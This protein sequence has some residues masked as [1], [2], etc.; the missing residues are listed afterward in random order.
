M[1]GPQTRVLKLSVLDE[2]E[3]K[4]ELIGDTIIQLQPAYDSNPVDGYDEWHPLTYKGKYAGEVYLELTFYSSRPALPAKQ[5]VHKNSSRQIVSA[6]SGS[7]M[8]S[9]TFTSS[10]SLSM[11]TAS[12]PL[13]EQPCVNNGTRPLRQNLVT[14]PLGGMSTP[15]L[16]QVPSRS[17]PGTVRHVGL[18]AAIRYV[19]PTGIVYDMNSSTNTLPY[20]GGIG[21]G[22]QSQPA[23]IEIS[24]LHGMR[25]GTPGYPMDSREPSPSGFM[26][27][28]TVS[29]S[30][31]NPADYQMEREFVNLPAIPPE[32][33]SVHREDPTWI[34]EEDPM[35]FFSIPLP[36]MEQQKP[37]EY[38]KEE[39]ED[40]S[41]RENPYE[42]KSATHLY[43]PTK[44]SPLT[45]STSS[46]ETVEDPFQPVTPKTDS[47]RGSSNSSGSNSES[48]DSPDQPHYPA[49]QPPVQK[50][51]SA[52]GI[53]T[54]PTT[55]EG[56]KPTAVRRKPITR[57]S[58][59]PP[60]MQDG[61]N[62]SQPG[63]DDSDTGEIDVFSPDSYISAKQQEQ[64]K[65]QQLQQEQE[66]KLK[67]TLH[68]STYAPQ[69]VFVTPA[70]PLP[71]APGDLVDPGVGRYLGEGQWDLTNEL[72]AGYCEDVY[73]GV[74][75]NQFSRQY[76]N[77][78]PKN[79]LRYNK[80]RLSLP[81]PPSRV[82]I[83]GGF[84]STNQ[85]AH[86]LATRK[87]SVRR[88]PRV[89]PKIPVG[90]TCEEFIATEYSYYSDE[91]D[92]IRYIN[93]ID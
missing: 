52:G 54:A 69:P 63:K 21:A 10:V 32:N 47:Y 8:G 4:P 1:E 7:V 26:N 85:H 29:R 68:E 37:Q 33:P 5:P 6:P 11:S 45:L 79:N 12:R 66:A 92:G 71:Q 23:L 13:P 27:M 65:L 46:N 50:R 2:T 42:N 51:T 53:S 77:A 30:L 58:V 22:Q 73:D 82:D 83:N 93:A 87:E 72:N 19:P 35:A 75:K 9:S 88:K 59:S 44:P 39:V 48:Q 67:D 24:P 74:I 70:K 76:N 64:L 34:Q 3:T 89:P 31:P 91:D 14:H 38:E 62:R 28:S 36:P 16:S 49:P 56:K 78:N 25:G 18:P 90:M 57:K 20:G 81:E 41:S 84:S 55:E 86:P 15:T 80:P 17:T 40:K 60:N 61:G 43:S